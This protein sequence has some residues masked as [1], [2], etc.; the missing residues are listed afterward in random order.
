MEDDKFRLAPEKCPCKGC[1]DR[2]PGCHT[3][4]CPHGWYEWDQ[5]MIKRREEINKERQ[6]YARYRLYRQQVM[7][8]FKR[9]GRSQ[10]Y[11]KRQKGEW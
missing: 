3:I 9:R 6:E 4:Q 10:S 2:H 1:E 8:N 11:R 7:D 5:Y